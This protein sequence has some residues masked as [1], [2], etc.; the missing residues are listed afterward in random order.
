MTYVF[1]FPP[2]PPPWKTASIYQGSLALKDRKWP[3]QTAVC[4][5]LGSVPGSLDIRTRAAAGTRP[6]SWLRR[7]SKPKL[8]DS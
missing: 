4:P 8:S 5:N 2:R 1:V 7:L 6:G 3:R